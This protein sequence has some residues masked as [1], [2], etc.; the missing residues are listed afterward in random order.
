[1]HCL[2]ESVLAVTHVLDEA[3][4][5]DALRRLEAWQ[6]HRASVRPLVDAAWGYRHNMTAG[7]ALYVALAEHLGADSALDTGM[8]R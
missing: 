2:I 1:M 4:G 6:L 5:S 7:D 3:Q 8:S